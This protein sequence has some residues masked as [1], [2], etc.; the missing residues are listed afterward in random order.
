MKHNHYEKG[1]LFPFPPYQ[2][3]TIL[4]VIVQDCPY[5]REQVS[6]GALKLTAEAAEAL[7][8]F[9]SP[10]IGKQTV[11]RVAEE[12]WVEVSG[13]VSS[14]SDRAVFFRNEQHA[15]WIPNQFFQKDASRSDG[16]EDVVA[17]IPRWLAVHDG[18]L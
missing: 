15:G 5:V 17:F 2:D 12:G 9:S 13:V 16:D 7:E 10:V 3:K 1:D 6:N 4:Q 14:T 11:S 8:A 18:F